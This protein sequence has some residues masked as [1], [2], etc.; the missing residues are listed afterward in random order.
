M[1][2]TDHYLKTE[3]LL[4]HAAGMAGVNVAPEDLPELLGRQRLAGDMGARTLRHR[5][6]KPCHIRLLPPL[7]I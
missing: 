1:T 4:G 7:A 6:G 5:E 3:R 2:S